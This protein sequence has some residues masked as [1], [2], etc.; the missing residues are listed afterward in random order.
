MAKDDLSDVKNL[1]ISQRAK[2]SALI[3]VDGDQAL[4]QHLLGAIGRS[5]AARGAR[6][7]AREVPDRWTQ[8]HVLDRLEEGYEV[9]AGMPMAT[10][11][12]VFGG[13]WPSFQQEKL[14]IGDQ[15][16][17]METGELEHLHED[18]NRV[19]M[20]ATSAQVTRMEQAL[21]WPFEYLSDKPD[22][23]KAI[24]LRAMWAVMRTDIRKRCERRGIDH[25]QFN[26]QWQA[27]L[28]IVTAMLIARKVPVS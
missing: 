7:G 8:I 21:R 15:V 22:L 5:E 26:R 19:R 16:N 9:L 17:L 18:R 4:R 20:A 23:A 1:S 27:G 14:S 11:P 25:D 2:L 6:G 3:E 24:S 13:A 10:R 12:K 28:N